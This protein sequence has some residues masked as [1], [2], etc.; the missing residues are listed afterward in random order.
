MGNV[1]YQPYV[2]PEDIAVVSYRYLQP[3]R[4]IPR[5][6]FCTVQLAEAGYHTHGN[7]DAAGLAP[8]MTT[9]GVL[10]VS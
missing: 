6:Y 2:H 9:G 8:S 3:P 4:R 10:C 5:N 1:P 7:C